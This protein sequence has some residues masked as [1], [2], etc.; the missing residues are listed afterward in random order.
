M[1]TPTRKTSDGNSRYGGGSAGPETRYCQDQADEDRWDEA[2]EGKSPKSPLHAD[3]PREAAAV[4]NTMAGPPR[5]S[6][7]GASY[8][9]DKWR[10]GF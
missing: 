9:T 10:K 1:A 6:C 5:G 2:K 7:M 8:P 4:V 3:M